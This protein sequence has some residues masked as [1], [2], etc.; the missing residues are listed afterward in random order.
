MVKAKVLKVKLLKKVTR[1]KKYVKRQL[2]NAPN[3][4]YAEAISRV[5]KTLEIGR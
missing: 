3:G 4:D 5:K 1:N 2:R